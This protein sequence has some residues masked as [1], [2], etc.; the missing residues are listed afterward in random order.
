MKNFVYDNSVSIKLDKTTQELVSKFNQLYN[1]LKNFKSENDFAEEIKQLKKIL[2]KIFDFIKKQI[3]NK[4][5]IIFFNEL[6]EFSF[7]LLNEDLLYF[8]SRKKLGKTSNPF[9][10]EKYISGQIGFLSRF[11]IK[12]LTYPK[13]LK[14]NKNVSKGLIK[15]EELSVNKG[16]IIYFLTLILNIEFKRKKILKLLSDYKRKDLMVVGLSLEKSIPS[17]WWEIY[18]VNKTPKTTYLHFDESIGNPKSIMYLS[19]VM[20][21]NGPFSILTNPNNYFK[22]SPIQFLIG[23]I[24]GNVGRNG[25]PIHHLFDHKYHQ[26]LGCDKFKS[27]FDKIPKEIKFNSHFGFD[28]VKNSE[29]EKNLINNELKFEG[30]YGD[31]FI[32]DGSETLHRGGLIEKDSRLVF[33][34]IFGAKKKYHLFHKI[35]NYI[36]RNV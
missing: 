14:L 28:V 18:D 26:P 25:S 7:K 2:K 5:E 31:Y 17:K 12:I 9:R 3:S 34:I 27:F 1:N 10:K 23:R 32:F 8:K 16:I 6:S 30:N 22:F 20:S 21:K 15:R 36:R 33:Q 24:I 13:I 35:K 4:N 19:N 29:L 11:L